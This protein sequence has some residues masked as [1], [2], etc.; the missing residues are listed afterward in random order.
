MFVVL[1]FVVGHFK[2]RFLLSNLMMHFFKLRSSQFA[3]T[4]FHVTL[5]NH[6]ANICR[7]EEALFI[8]CKLKEV[9]AKRGSIYAIV[10]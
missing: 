10:F 1:I 7:A 2:K 6:A 5:H 9:S 4:I 3:T 8:T